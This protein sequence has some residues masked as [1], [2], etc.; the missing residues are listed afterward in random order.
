QRTVHKPQAIQHQ[1]L[2]RLT[3]THLAPSRADT[4]VNLPDEVNLLAYPGHNPQMVELLCANLALVHVLVILVG[5]AP[6]LAY[7][8]I[9]PFFHPAAECGLNIDSTKILCCTKDRKCVDMTKR[10]DHRSRT[11][12][13]DCRASQFK[14]RLI[15]FLMKT[16]S[17]T[18]ST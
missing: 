6:A 2:D 5:T 12:R 1:R 7:P 9:L 17:N 4:L 14:T 15:V 16:L 3:Y 10:N 18:L 11:V 8:I 13:Y